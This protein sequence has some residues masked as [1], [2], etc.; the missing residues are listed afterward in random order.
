MKMNEINEA[1]SQMVD[2]GIISMSV[3]EEGEII[4]YMSE[5]QRKTAEGQ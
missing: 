2:E 3:N 4:F 1:L 5:E